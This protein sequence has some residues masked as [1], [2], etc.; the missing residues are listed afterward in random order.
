MEK[1]SN[2]GAT[3]LGQRL[4][5]LANGFTI[6]LVALFFDHFTPSWC[7]IAYVVID[8]LF[9]ARRSDASIINASLSSRIRLLSLGAWSSMCVAYLAWV[10]G[11]R[12]IIVY[13]GVTGQGFNL[14]LWS[15]MALQ[16]DGPRDTV[17]V[18]QEAHLDAAVSF[19][20]S[21]YCLTHRPWIWALMTW[22]LTR[23]GPPL[24][25]ISMASYYFRASLPPARIYRRVLY[26]SS[27]SLAQ[28]WNWY[29]YCEAQIV[30]R[31]PRYL[32][33]Q[34]S[35]Y[36]QRLPERAKLP[37][38]KYRPLNAGDIRLLVIQKSPYYP[39]VIEVKIVH[40][41]INPTPDYE[42]ISYR[43]GS[44]ELTHEILVD[45][46]RFP[47]T[48]AAFDVLLARRSV[49]RERIV[50]IDALCINQQDLQEKS[51]QVQLMRDIYGQAS[52]VVSFP[53]SDWRYRLAGGLIYQM[54]A[55]SHQYDTDALDWQAAHD[56]ANSA[57]WRAMADLFS[58]EYFNR[59]WVI[60][61]VSVGQKNQLY[62]GGIYIPWVI[63]TDHGSVLQWCM[64]P[65][66][67]HMLAGSHTTERRTW[68]SGRT[69]ENVVV[70]MMLREADDE[71]GAAVRSTGLCYPEGLLYLTS[72][73]KATD[74]RDKVFALMGIISGTED[75]AL[76]MPDYTLP[77]EE[78]FQITAKAIFSLPSERSTVH[79]LALAGTGF[80][81]YSGGMP[82][83]V[84]DYSQERR[85]GLLYSDILGTSTRFRASGDLQQNLFID[86]ATNSLVV[87]AISIDSVID[88]S[89]KPALDW[90]LRDLELADAFII[91][92]T[93]HGFVD[94]AIKLCQKHE[95]TS[96]TSSVSHFE[97][98]W[99]VLICGLIERQPANEMFK[100]ISRRWWQNLGLM[101]SV[102]N[103]QELENN[104]TLGDDWAT[105]KDGS[106][107]LY[108]QSVIEACL[109]RRIAITRAGRLC[110]V[111]P[112]AKAGDSI[113]IPMGSQTPFLVRSRGGDEDVDYELVGEAWVEGVMNGE[114][115]GT[116]Q[117]ESIRII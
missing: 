25:F 80:S 109:G 112:F 16:H 28:I 75:A 30:E 36:Q 100:H 44:S 98:L 19:L 33:H 103:H 79:M 108:Q 60:Q 46:C 1:I 90:G 24:L 15:G 37:T 29:D 47:V 73:F 102:K 106:V 9:Q 65:N 77:V 89:N 110:I 31:V 97:R 94:A 5:N 117:E 45:G 92:R 43:W 12:L 105:D 78:V 50:W 99:L 74:P 3:L 42:A 69:F 4:S 101:A 40:R 56:E 81:E 114:K 58:N 48:E 7:K 72:N 22:M 107:R 11:H 116:I 66:R 63:F 13:H 10:P 38:Y 85:I 55:F 8:H 61:E 96:G 53:G 39:S 59:A 32:Q 51:E 52:R 88:L 93:L 6:A 18:I 115:I 35:S 17:N 34:W 71:Q 68:R 111:P 86:Y 26:Y 23:L 41:P 70:M 20:I 54:W 21:S 27:M 83:W 62:V 57:P 84:P 95:G 14:L 49:W 113:I 87:K 91:V 76:I 2:Y 104:A 64:K 67:R 82:S